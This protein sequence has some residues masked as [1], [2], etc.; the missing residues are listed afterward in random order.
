MAAA[1]EVAVGGNDWIADYVLQFMTSLPWTGPIEQFIDENCVIFDLPNA[2]D[3]K[4]EYTEVHTRF[5]DLV[6]SLLA[7]HLIEVDV[8]PEEF[9]AAFEANF[10]A[11][12]R[13]DNIATQLASVN[14]FLAFKEM[15]TTRLLEQQRSIMSQYE[16]P[17][18]EERHTEESFAV[19]NAALSTSA[20]AA[21]PTRST[22]VPEGGLPKSAGMANRIT[23]IIDGASK[24]KTDEKEK[25]AM[26][27][28]AL[29]ESAGRMKSARGLGC[30]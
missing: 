4:L 12:Q 17:P 14:D 23:A 15:M 20:H 13:F 10:K 27:R 3:N 21:A 6:D 9:A 25:A 30:A 18:P 22:M 19:A 7:A 11:D 24:A 26:V 2:E 8:S 29:A 1:E 16:S 28:V 5:K